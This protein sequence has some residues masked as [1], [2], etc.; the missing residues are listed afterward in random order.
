MRYS[1][2]LSDAVHILAYINIYHGT[3]LASATIATSVM[4]NPAMV[5]RLM[6]DLRRA[7]L[8]VTQPGA[9]QPRLARDPKT[10][11]LLDIYQ[12]LSDEG[13]LLHIDDETNPACIVGGNIQATLTAAYQRVQRAAEA[14]MAEQTLADLIAGILTREHAKA[15][16]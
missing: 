8:L 2:K 9:A 6:G 11:T 3:D 15:A 14:A 12:A 7:G 5:R 13:P 16:R 10:I 4:A 1:H